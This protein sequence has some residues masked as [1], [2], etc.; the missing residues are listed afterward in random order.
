MFDR[1]NTCRFCDG[2]MSQDLVKSEGQGIRQCTTTI[3]FAAG[4]IP[5]HGM[6]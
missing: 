6:P 3:G 5:F 2:K 1:W 4:C